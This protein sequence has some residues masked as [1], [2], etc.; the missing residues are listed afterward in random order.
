MKEKLTLGWSPEQISIRLPVDFPGDG[1]MRVSHETIYSFIYDQ[2]NRRGQS[3][4]G[5]GG[6]RGS[7]AAAC[8][9]TKAADE[10]RRQESGK[11]GEKRSIALH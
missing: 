5:E 11:N 6:M 3:T 4:V 10:E 2:V 7:P 8:P 1:Q 9:K